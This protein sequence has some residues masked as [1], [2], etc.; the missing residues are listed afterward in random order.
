VV[1]RTVTTFH[2]DEE[3]EVDETPFVDRVLCTG[4]VRLL[5]QDRIE[6]D[7]IEQDR[8]VTRFMQRIYSKVKGRSLGPSQ[9]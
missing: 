6:Q 2:S 1:E 7:R 9:Y 4:S 5:L 8:Y 3:E